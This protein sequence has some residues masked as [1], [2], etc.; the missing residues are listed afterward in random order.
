MVQKTGEV[1]SV[2]GQCELLSLHRSGLFYRRC[3]TPAE[4]LALMR[5]I[6]EVHLRWPFY[7]SRRMTY[8]LGQEGRAVN[9]K[10]VQRLM[11]VMDIEAMAPG[12]NTSRPRKEDARFPYLLRG[13][14]VVRPHQVWAS[15]IT[16]IPLARGYAYLVA[17]IDWFARAVL[18]WRLSNTLDTAPCLEALDEALATYG[19]PE[20]FNS[21][22]GCQFTSDAFVD[23]L[24]RDGIQISRDGKGRCLDNVFVERLWRTVKYEEVYLKAYEDVRDARSGIGGYFAFYNDVRP[25]QGL[26]DLTPAAV[27]AG[28]K[29]PAGPTPIAALPVAPPSARGQ[30]NGAGQPPPTPVRYAPLL[31]AQPR[32]RHVH[33]QD[34][35][36]VRHQQVPGPLGQTRPTHSDLM[37]RLHGPDQGA[38]LRVREPNKQPV[39]ARVRDRWSSR[40]SHNLLISE[41]R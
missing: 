3:E 36:G 22:Q 34:T 41:S 15:D 6:D 14:A 5:L 24:Q 11:R 7:G 17:I 16:Y 31:V 18:S 35:A 1:P 8:A 20:I 38:V 37:L 12:P 39:L 30:A 27:L 23:R 29:P 21:D 19:A 10:R 13:L 2:R 33:R 9:R 4:D 28:A 25:H 32:A 26:G 40:T